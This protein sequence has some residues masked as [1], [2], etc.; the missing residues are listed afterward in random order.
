MTP[1][2]L[3]ELVHMHAAYLRRAAERRATARRLADTDQDRAEMATDEAN[4][5]LKSANALRAILETVPEV[6]TPDPRQLSIL[7]DG[8]H[9]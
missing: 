2:D 1:A 9:L 7:A 5:A 4:A 3:A 6:F 8:G